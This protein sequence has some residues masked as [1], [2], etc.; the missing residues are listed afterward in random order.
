[1][2]KNFGIAL[3]V[4]LILLSGC[5]QANH[6]KA[7]K[8]N[9]SIN[10][11][12]QPEI[13][14]PSITKITIPFTQYTKPALI[15]NSL[16][17]PVNDNSESINR[18][19][20]YDLN[21]R[22][23]STIYESKFK[24]STINNLLCNRRWMVWV[25]S[26]V[27]GGSSTIYVQDLRTNKRKVI[28]KVKDLKLTKVDAPTLYEDYVAWVR[29]NHKDAPEV[30]LYNLQTNK[31]TVLASL[32]DY[33]LY[34]NF[35]HAADGKILWTDSKD[36]IGYYYVYDIKN[37]AI[38]AHKGESPY[39][40]YAQL[41]GDK[42]FSINFE[43][44]GDWTKQKFGYYSTN[45]KKFVTLESNYINRFTAYGDRIAVINSKQELELYEIS[46]KGNAK[47][48][49]AKSLHPYVDSIDFM[50]DGTLITGYSD[51][52]RNSSVLFLIPA[53]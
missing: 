52:P 12:N 53:K 38:K 10:H 47:I 42:I 7:N 27:T 19:V 28:S 22:D 11:L 51:E 45:D 20:R 35:L 5:S 30:M 26:E 50:Y 46:N 29:I 3:L 31:T 33:S 41:A 36:G 24:E 13:S 4:V 23:I 32:D 1:M 40:G 34:N 6:G 25:D 18:I 43:D 14:V 9:A 2:K 8:T 17:I 48:N 21:N 16:Y 15:D 49:L 39:L 44:V 37:H